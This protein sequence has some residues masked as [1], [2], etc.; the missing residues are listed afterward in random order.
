L[1]PYLVSEGA[2]AFWGSILVSLAAL[3]L[4]GVIS[5]RLF[6][7]RIAQNGVKMLLLGGLAIAVG[8][9]VGTLVPNAS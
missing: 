7:I 5:A 4:L 6:G 9:I 1:A 2:V 3:F 8:V